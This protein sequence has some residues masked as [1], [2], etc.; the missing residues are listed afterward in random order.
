VVTKPTGYPAAGAHSYVTGHESPMNQRWGGWYV[1]GAQGPEI[2]MGNALE[3]FNSADYLTGSSDVV[4]LMVLAH[5]TQ[6][7]NLITLTN[8][9][10]RLALSADSQ[11]SDATRKKIEA[12]AEQ[13]VRYLLFTNEAPL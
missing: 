11:I 10:T 2:A 12:P 9:Q 3:H 7:H 1:S 4:A 6:T 13:L 5:Q 8:Y